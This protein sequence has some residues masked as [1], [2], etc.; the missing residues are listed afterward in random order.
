MAGLNSEVATVD[1]AAREKLKAC[2][3]RAFENENGEGETNQRDESR[4]FDRQTAIMR[5][6]D[7]PKRDRHDQ[8]RQQ[9]KDGHRQRD[10]AARRIA[11]HEET[12]DGAAKGAE[13]KLAGDGRSYAELLQLVVAAHAAH[14]FQERL[15][16]EKNRDAIADDGQRRGDSKAGEE[17]HHCRHRDCSDKAGEET[18]KKRF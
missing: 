18:D 5:A 4:R 9:N 16:F 2:Q 14:Q 11:S 17:E 6:E 13:E 12:K 15:R 7:R 8:R 1:R 3:E 10:G